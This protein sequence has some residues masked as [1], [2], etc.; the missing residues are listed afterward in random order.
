[1][2]RLEYMGNTSQLEML[3]IP[4]LAKEAGDI[5]PQGLR[6]ILRRHGIS[7]DAVLVEGSVRSELFLRARVAQV[8]QLING[9]KNESIS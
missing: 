1:M 3:T 2:F 6:K 7:G 5:S 4:G 8:K 9:K